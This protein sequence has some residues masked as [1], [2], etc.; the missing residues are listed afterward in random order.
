MNCENSFCIYQSKG[1]CILE[2]VNINSVGMCAECIYPDID[3]DLINQ[4]KL[5]LLKQYE[6][7][8]KI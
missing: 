2:T 3:D 5:E 1:Q 6:K 7:T 4:A 8:D